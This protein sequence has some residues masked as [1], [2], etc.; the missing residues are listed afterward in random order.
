MASLDQNKSIG[1]CFI[2]WQRAAR[3]IAVAQFVHRRWRVL[4]LEQLE[5]GAWRAWRG[6]AAADRVDSQAQDTFRLWL[7]VGRQALSAAPM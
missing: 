6:S 5:V 3:R 7:R 4:G 2:R 1:A